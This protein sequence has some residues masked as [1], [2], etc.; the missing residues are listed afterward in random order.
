[1]TATADASK[2]D[3]P[4]ERRETRIA[5]QARQ[6]REILESCPAALV[7]VDEE[8]RLLLG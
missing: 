1:M 8:E 6:F 2:R 4:S 3:E 5:E 7:V